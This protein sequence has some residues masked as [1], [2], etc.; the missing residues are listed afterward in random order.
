VV[1]VADDLMWSTRIT[2]AVRRAGG[3]AVPLSSD[4]ELSVALEAFEQGD[5]HS[6]S[7]AVVDLAARRLDGVA[8]IARISSARLPVI[9][10]AEHDDQL[11]RKRAL[12]AG[13]MRV[14]SYRK[15][16]EDGTRLVQGWLAANAADHG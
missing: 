2:E 1:V 8:A 12:E 5:V 13:A 14:F 10:V 9:A 3:A 16:F 4:S 11:T 15:F 6:I 7:G